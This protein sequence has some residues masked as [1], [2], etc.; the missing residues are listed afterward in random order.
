MKAVQPPFRRTYA[1]HG[2]LQI[3]AAPRV[4][5][6]V[7]KSCAML[8]CSCGRSISQSTAV[9]R[10]HRALPVNEDW[11]KIRDPVERRKMQNRIAQRNYR[12]RRANINPHSPAKARVGKKIKQRLALLESRASSEVLR[13]IV[14]HLNRVRGNVFDI[15]SRSPRRFRPLMSS[16]QRIYTRVETTT[17]KDAASYRRSSMLTSSRMLC[18]LLHPRHRQRHRH[19]AW[20]QKPRHGQSIVPLTRPITYQPLWSTRLCHLRSITLQQRDITSAATVVR[21]RQVTWR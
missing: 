21:S 2:S 7:R 9:K 12:K 16:A 20:L 15:R 17:C 8:Y 1:L 13:L 10:P 4:H 5:R 19:L 11:S 3:S 14:P 6:S 18:C